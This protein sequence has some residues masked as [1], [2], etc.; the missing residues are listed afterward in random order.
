M[1]NFN[2]GDLIEFK[3]SSSNPSQVRRV[4][5]EKMTTTYVEGWQIDGDTSSYKK[6]IRSNINT[7]TVIPCKT[8]PAESDDYADEIFTKMLKAK[9]SKNVKWAYVRNDGLLVGWADEPK[10]VNIVYDG[11]TRRLTIKN[12]SND[13]SKIFNLNY[14]NEVGPAYGDR[15][16]LNEF[17]D[18]LKTLL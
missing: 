18:S 16:S 14:S 6:F 12:G 1:S 7:S 9:S 11:Y 2:V 8:L 15:L 3:Y 4:Y 13:K 17:I 5:V 10:T